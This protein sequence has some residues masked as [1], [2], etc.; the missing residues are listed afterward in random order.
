MAG[1]VCQGGMAWRHGVAWAMAAAVAVTIAPASAGKGEE[2]R[3]QRQSKGGWVRAGTRA[4]KHA[5]CHGA[6]SDATETLRHAAAGQAKPSK[7][8]QAKPSVAK[9]SPEVANGKSRTCS[10]ASFWKYFC[11]CVRIC[12]TVRLG[13]MLA[14]FFHSR[15]NSCRPVT[16]R[17]CSS[18]VQRPAQRAHEEGHCKSRTQAA[19]QGQ[20]RRHRQGR[21]TSRHSTVHKSHFEP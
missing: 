13:I 9:A 20:R 16:K 12:T 3:G 1:A 18:F 14:T 19:T 6:R 11:A 8:S 4:E 17:W 2:A 5:A 7:P 15:P 21:A 10:L